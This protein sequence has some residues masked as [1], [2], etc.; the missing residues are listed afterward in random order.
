MFVFGERHEVDVV[1]PSDDEDP[2]ALI[3]V[4]L[5]ALEDV[6]KVT[7]LNMEDDVLESNAAARP[8]P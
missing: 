2:L 1:A 7:A 8:K 5:V 6:E 3:A 4:Q